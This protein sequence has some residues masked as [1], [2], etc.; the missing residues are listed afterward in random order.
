MS[1]MQLAAVPPADAARCR[2]GDDVSAFANLFA[3]DVDLVIWRRPIEPVLHRFARD[4]LA[5]DELECLRELTLAELP[6]LS[7]LPRAAKHADPAAAAA[8]DADLRFLV[9][10]FAE[11][12]SAVRIGLRLVRLSGPM[13]PRFHTD[14]VGVRL[15]TT[16]C[17]AGTEWL[18]AAQVDRRFLGHR[19]NGQPD[20]TSGL[21]RPGAA[22][23]QVPEFAV[24]LLKGDA[25]PG[26]GERGVVHRSPS[27][28]RPRVLLSL[29]VLAQEGGFDGFDLSG[30][31][32]PAP[33]V[34]AE[35]MGDDPARIDA[36]QDHG[37]GGTCGSGR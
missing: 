2:I 10:A 18:P 1:S 11:L 33:L 6:R 9:R 16:Y 4:V 26:H 35:S 23:Q 37:C 17:G 15:L 34:G 5:K 31:G 8:F 28:Q 12:T 13:C 22:V 21:L 36:H 25:W 30:A 27:S 24:A 14:F 3:P 7:P 32:R 19:S 20:D 29:D